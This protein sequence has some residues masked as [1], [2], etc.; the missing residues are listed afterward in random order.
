MGKWKQ[1]KLPDTWECSECGWEIYG[2]NKTNFCPSC[3][4]DKQDHEEWTMAEVIRQNMTELIKNYK[5]YKDDPDV[6]W[7]CDEYGGYLADMIDCHVV[8]QGEP[9]CLCKGRGIDIYPKSKEERIK[10]DAACA[11]CKAIWLMGVYE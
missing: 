11:E 1:S 10:R 6:C 5:E 4:D 7:W 2:D 8:F 9:P 3:G